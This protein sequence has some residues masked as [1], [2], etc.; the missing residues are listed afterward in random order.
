MR[1]WLIVIVLLLSFI[2]LATSLDE[3]DRIS[4]ALHRANLWFLVIAL[5]VQ[6]VWFFILGQTFRSIYHLLGLKEDTFRLT[7]V[8]IAA[9]FINVIAPTGGAGGMALFIAD[10]KARGHSSGKVTAAGAISLFFDYLAFL[11]ILVLGVIVLFR[12]NNLDAGELAASF[13]ILVI[14]L[15]LATILYLGSR[16]GER[17]A[18]F[19][20]YL[21]QMV[22][23]VV[24]LVIKR[25]L[26][27]VERARTF[28]FDL[29][30]GLAA[31]PGT[32]WRMMVPFLLALANKTALILVLTLSFLA[33]GVPFTEGTII[34]GFAIGY[35]FMIV[36]PTPAGVGVMESVFILAL[37]SLHVEWSA[38]IVIALTYRAVTFWVP[39]GVGTLAFQYLGRAKRDRGEPDMF[40]EV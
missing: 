11:C 28:A 20:G 16:S 23:R 31:M 1:K 21:G 30:E 27:D 29:A 9:N 32:P 5:C 39:L 38:A 18:Y 19:L 17:L 6:L 12:R 3:L 35:L 34:G 7:L 4:G 14:T 37:N 15:V 24:D 26:L 2:F 22:N 40:F 10:G 25:E 36:S 33:F 8:A 13:I